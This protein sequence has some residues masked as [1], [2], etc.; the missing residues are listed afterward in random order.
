MSPASRARGA[1]PGLAGVGRKARHPAGAQAAM[2]QHSMGCPVLGGD[3][4]I[5]TL[6]TFFNLIL[7]IND[8]H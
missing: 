3:I 4:P 6:T 5:T 2:A 7:E 1:P 8:I